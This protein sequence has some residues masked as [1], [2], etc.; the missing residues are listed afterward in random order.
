MIRYP[1]PQSA[2]VRPAGSLALP[3]QGRWRK[4]RFAWGAPQTNG[5]LARH[6]QVEADDTAAKKSRLLVE[7]REFHQRGLGGF[8]AFGKSNRLPRL[9][10]QVPAPATD[11]SRRRKLW[12][13][14]GNRAHQPIELPLLPIGG[15]PD[16][17]RQVGH[18]ID[19]N[20]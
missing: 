3:R 17:Q 10:V 20:A 8:L 2:S 5:H 19:G 13:Q 12:L 9:E 14:S 15:G 11:P 18:L 4:D 6:A 16:Q 7:A 1:K